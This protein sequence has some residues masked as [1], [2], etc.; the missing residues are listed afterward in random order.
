MVETNYRGDRNHKFLVRGL[1]GTSAET[2]MINHNGADIS[3]F[4]YFEEHYNL[5]IRYV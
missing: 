1:T 4:K 3:I 2:Q 5:T